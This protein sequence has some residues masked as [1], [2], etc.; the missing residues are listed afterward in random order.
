[1]S[2]YQY[3]EYQ[4]NDDGYGV[5][6]F[7]EEP[8][9]EKK[10]KKEH[11]FLK[12][13]GKTVAIAVVFGL[14]SG[15]VF[16]GTGYIANRALGESNTVA[17]E[18]AEDSSTSGKALSTSS[19]KVDSTKVSTATTV[20]DVSDIAENVMPSIVAVTNV[21]LVE[22]RNFFGIGQQEVESAGSGI[23][24][25]QDDN[26][27]YIATNNH[28]VE[29]TKSLTITFCDDSAVAAEVQ[30][31]D[32]ET[33]LAVI[34]VKLGDISAD[35]LSAIKVATLGSSEDLR[36]G[37]S[38]IVIGNAL[39]Y[40]QSVT[41]GVVSALGREVSLTNE[42]SGQTYTNTL[43][44]TNAAV[45]PG[46]SGGALLNMNGEVI[47]IVSAKYSDTDVE[48]MGYAIPITDASEIIT[49]LMNSGTVT[50][51]PEKDGE[52]ASTQGGYLGIY[53]VDISK[54]E[55][56]AYSI[57]QGVYVASVIDGGGAKNAGIT[58]GDVITA[59]NDKQI[60][61]MADM[62]KLLSDYKPGDTVT[63]TLSQANNNYAQA[64]VQVTLTEKLQ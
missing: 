17:E 30:G 2:N 23:I 62:Q 31:T 54:S 27:L 59:I 8:P 50:N 48:G 16:Q 53:G 7:H 44:Q 20:N 41:T 34:K 58:K 9:K 51:R 6:P 42:T 38:T 46:N 3:Y 5:P 47:G 21:S 56:V 57:P 52:E 1:M 40:G 11:K 15:C 39:G 43:I 14:V 36:V 45:N 26:Y 13:L 24:I 22:Y 19:D 33:D 28:V 63:V 29:G 64:T 12:T 61:S 60:S 18:S 32:E 49:Q 10:P 55:S 25:S 35:T 37:E 4:P